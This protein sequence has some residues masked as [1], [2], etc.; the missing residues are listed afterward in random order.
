MENITDYTER[1]SALCYKHDNVEKEL[2][3]KFGV[4]KRP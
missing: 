2:Y 1:Q 3:S 4:K